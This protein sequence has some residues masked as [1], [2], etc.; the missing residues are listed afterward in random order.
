MSPSRQ[1]VDAR[2]ERRR[3]ELAPG[4]DRRRAA[5]RGPRG[6]AVAR[7]PPEVHRAPV[8]EGRE[9]VLDD[10]CGLDGLAVGLVRRDGGGSP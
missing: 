1:R 5:G 7:K 3:R 9:P 6:R 10:G 4:L 2:R 8:N